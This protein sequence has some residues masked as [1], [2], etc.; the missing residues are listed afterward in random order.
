MAP[1]L[2]ERAPELQ[3][4]SVRG[5]A[6]VRGYTIPWILPLQVNRDLERVKAHFI[7]ADTAEL[8]LNGVPR[9]QVQSQA[10]GV[11]VRLIDDA[12]GLAKFV[13]EVEDHRVPPG[14][15]HLVELPPRC[16]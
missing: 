3:P 7:E 16:L 15:E 13:I 12:Q 5:L 4:C 14:L 10:I 9:A 8:L 1:R 2:I 6:G 11:Q